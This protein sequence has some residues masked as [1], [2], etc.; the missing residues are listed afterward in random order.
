MSSNYLTLNPAKTE[1]LLIGLPQQTSRIA[2]PSLSLPTTKPIMPSLPAKNLCFIFDSTLSFSKQNSSLSSACHYHICDLHRIRHTLDYTTA[3]TIITALVHSRLDYCNYLYHGL[4][5]TQINRLQHIQ[6]GLA[7]AVTR[8]LKRSHIYPVLKS[9]HWLTFEQ[10]IQ[11]KIISITNNL[12]HITEPKYLHR[13]INIKPPSRTRSSDHMCLF[14]AS[15][16]LKFADRSFR[17]YSPHLSNSL[18]INLRSF[19]PDTHHSTTVTSSTPSHPC[20]ALSLSR[21]QFLSC[22]ET[23]L[24]TLS[25]PP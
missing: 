11:Y 12:L 5:I 10:R 3:T 2:N 19:A 23:Q 21:S 15:T 9:L 24:F 25:Y 17:N 16:R 20:R 13:L 6:I 14:L 8:T 18:P 1:F 4:P 7:R 22:L